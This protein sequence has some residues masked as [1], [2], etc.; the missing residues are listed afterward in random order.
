MRARRHWDRVSAYDKPGTWVRRVTINLAL[1][2][3]RK[4]ALEAKARL[5]WWE[6]REPAEES[7]ALDPDLIAA[8]RALSPRQRA[9]VSL[10]Y[11]EDRSTPEIAE[12]PRLL[13]VHRASPPA[14][15]PPSARPRARSQAM[16]DHDTLPPEVDDEIRARLQ[17]FAREV[18]EHADTETALGRMPRR[19]APVH[20]PAD[21]RHRCRAC[22]RS[23]PWPSCSSQSRRRSTTRIR[24]SRHDDRLPDHHPATSHQLRRTDEDEVRSSRRQRGD[25]RHAA[26]CVRT[27]TP[28]D[29]PRGSGEGSSWA[30]SRSGTPGPRGGD[31]DHQRRGRGRRGHRRDPGYRE[32]DHASSA[33]TPTPTASSSSAAR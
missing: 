1:S 16:S 31:A 30:T 10:H 18:A 12:S 6:R 15:R 7:Q 32:R 26:R 2:S 27:M 25:R 17:A 8:L 23:S 14:S 4:L 13:G 11:L 20:H 3:R 21:G 29:E 33:R 9:A 5:A 28:S 22:S 19:L 24:R